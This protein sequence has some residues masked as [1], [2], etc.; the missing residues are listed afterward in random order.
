MKNIKIMLLFATILLLLVGVA[1]AGEVSEDITDTGS[2]TQEAV[3]QDTHKV[4]DTAKSI[5]ENYVDENIQTV[6]ASDDNLNENVTKTIAKTPKDSTLKKEPI[7][8]ILYRVNN[9]KGLTAAVKSAA[10]RKENVT[11][12]LDSGTYINTGT[13]KWTNTKN[14]LTINGNG[15]TIDGNQMLVFDI[16]DDTNIILKNIT[17]KN[18]KSKYGGAISS[19]GNI[20]ITDSTFED[21][22]ATEYGGA[23]ASFGKLYVINSTFDYNFAF[24]YGGALMSSKSGELRIVDSSFTGNYAPKGAAI[25]SYGTNNITGNTFTENI[26]TNN[27][28]ID[29]AGLYNGKLSSNVYNSTDVALKTVN[30]SVTGN[31]TIFDEGEEI[32]L[33]FDIALKRPHYYDKNLVERLEDIKIFINNIKYDTTTYKNYTLS[34]L[35]PG[36]YKVY[37]RTCNHFSNTVTFKVIARNITNWQQLRDAVGD[38]ESQRATKTITLG[39]GTYINTG[40]IVWDN[41]DT[42]LTINGNGQTIDGNQLQVFNITVGST[43]ILKNI[44]IQNAKSYYG[45]AIRNSGRLTI[46]QSTLANNTSI[47]DGGAIYNDWGKL[48]ITESTLANNTARKGGVI[49]NVN[50]EYFNISSSNITNNHAQIGGAIHTEGYANLKG[51]IFTNNTADNRETIDLFGWTNGLVNGN[52]YEDTDISLN[53]VLSVKED[54]ESFEYGEDVLLKFSI[55]LEHPNYYDEDVLDQI[56][57]T[58]YINGEKNVTTEN[59]NYTLSNLNPGRYTLY[60]TAA[61]QKS[62]TVTFTVNNSENETVNIN[63]STQTTPTHLIITVKDDSTNPITDGTITTNLTGNRYYPDENGQVFIAL[64]DFETGQYTANVSYADN[65]GDEVSDNVTFN[66]FEP[67]NSINLTTS[68]VEMVKERSVMLEAYVDYKNRTIKYGKVYFEID[69]KPLVDENGLVLYAPV[70][71]NWAYLPYQIPIELSLGNHTLT[72]V[73]IASTSTWTTDNKTL[74]IIDNIPEGAGDEDKTQVEETGSQQR[75]TKDTPRYKTMTKYTKTAQSTTP[76]SHKVVTDD[77]MIPI[78]NTIT[79]GQLNEIFGQTFTNGHLLLYIDGQLVFNGTVGD[80][81]ATVILE[82]VEKYLGGHELKVVF[83]DADG[84]TNTYTKNVT[85]T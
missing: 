52:R 11:I 39:E 10:S 79:L 44:T 17:I 28:T 58:L 71:D 59:E 56:D 32:V 57:K 33:Y 22:V 29:L 82:I 62:N 54:K 53:N 13:I 43:M 84:K 41:T 50:R 42:I 23:I 21:N 36:E 80:D 72:A 48:N 16:G 49:H 78:E 40:T 81:L 65:S 61:N 46:T 7:H 6:K 75:Y 63:L 18:A 5:Q 34:K 27:E 24:N 15:Q 35:E 9:W 31:Y 25:Y 51:N 37:Y 76:T 55:E 1:S 74:T 20:N 12:E 83:T 45:G 2:I 60:F 85:I 3:T 26:A 77:N 70:K 8:Y 19:F 66:V 67:T 30:L 68:D 73:Y 47:Y 14:V 69:G 64:D 4:S 38:V